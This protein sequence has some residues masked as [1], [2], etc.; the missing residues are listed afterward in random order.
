MKRL[1]LVV[2][3]ITSLFLVLSC[4]DSTRSDTDKV[5]LTEKDCRGRI[6]AFDVV[7]NPFA[8]Q[9]QVWTL[10]GVRF[11]KPLGGENNVAVFEEMIY[12]KFFLVYDVPLSEYKGPLDR[13]T[14]LPITVEVIGMTDAKNAYGA[15]IRVPLFRFIRREPG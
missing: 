15:T 12:N 7:H 11:V 4:S 6:R 1:C 5:V 8:Y 2:W 14:Y 10:V 9:N 3:I 13:S